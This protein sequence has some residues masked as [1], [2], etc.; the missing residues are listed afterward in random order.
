MAIPITIPRVGWNMDEGLFAGWTK[1][2]GEPV[3]SGDFIFSLETDKA[4][5][6]IECLDS[7]ILW[8]PPEGPKAG[9]KVTVGM[10]IGYLKGP[11]WSRARRPSPASARMTHGR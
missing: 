11:A 8:I 7:G 5:Q 10:V 2:E 4:I 3:K 6:E 9:D 1:A